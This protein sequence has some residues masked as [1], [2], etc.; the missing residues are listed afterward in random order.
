MIISKNKS[1]F[2]DSVIVLDDM[3]DKL[4]KDKAYYFTEGRYY[5]IQMIVMCHKPA[6]IINTA[7][8]SCDTIYLTTYNGADLFKI[9]NEIY[10]CE[11]NFNKIISELNSN[12][13]NC[14]DGMSDELRYGIIK[15][16]RKENTSIIIDKNSTMIYDSRF[17]FLDLKALS[18][19]D[20]L[21]S[22]DKN[23][24]I[25]Y[26]KPLM[27]NAS[28]RNTINHDNY[29]FYFNKLLTSKGIKIQNDVLTQEIIEADGFRLAS[30]ILRIIGTCFMIYN[31]MSLDTTVKTAGHVATSVK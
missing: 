1:K 12:Y 30:T 25:A 19:K 4:K 26:M 29:Q 2:K 15:Y 9:F 23:K 16:N 22:E 13:Y 20:K 10:K 6:Q 11:P 27:I 14:T 24:L 3:G 21:E 17:G 8:M 7:R 18:L 5:T 31:Y 28:D